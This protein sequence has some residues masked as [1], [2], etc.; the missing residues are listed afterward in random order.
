MK[1]LTVR[2]E[3]F[4]GYEVT[5][6]V[7]GNTEDYAMALLHIFNNVR[8]SNRL[9]AIKNYSYNNNI[10]VYCSSESKDD[11]IE[12]LENFGEVKRC[13]KALCYRVDECYLP[14]RDYEEYHSEIVAPYF[15]SE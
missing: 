2:A 11:L 9:L 7:E 5:V 3:Q 15:Y 12:Y 10:T 6:K 1:E 8:E 13:E 4:E 14:E